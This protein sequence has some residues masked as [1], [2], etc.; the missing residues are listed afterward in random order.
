MDIDLRTQLL[1]CG[2]IL[3]T[4]INSIPEKRQTCVYGYLMEYCP[5]EILKKYE[6]TYSS[7]DVFN[8]SYS[9]LLEIRRELKRRS[10]AGIK[11]VKV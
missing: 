7:V 1:I 9:V 2:Q 5:N 11:I 10:E 6:K 8:P 3:E 4:A